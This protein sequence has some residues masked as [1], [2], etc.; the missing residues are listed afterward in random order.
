M[1]GCFDGKHT[2]PWIYGGSF[3]WNKNV[4]PNLANFISRSKSKR[5]GVHLVLYI[6]WN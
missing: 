2:G 6:M 5:L 1:C 3:G 4:F